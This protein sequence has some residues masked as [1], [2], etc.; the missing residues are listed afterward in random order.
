MI[1]VL[2]D[3]ISFIPG[4]DLGFSRGGGGGFSKILSTF[5]R[6]TELILSSS[7]YAQFSPCFSQNFCAAGKILKKQFKKG[8]FGTFGKF[9]PKNC[10]FFGARAP[11][12]LV[13]IGAKGAFRKILGLIGQKWIS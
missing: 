5:F 8:V 3:K 12:K 7:P 10:L 1:D 4:A 13:Y 2:N 9:L 11:S 6:S